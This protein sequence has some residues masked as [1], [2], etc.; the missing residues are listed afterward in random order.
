MPETGRGQF[1]PDRTSSHVDAQVIGF[2]SHF[3]ARWRAVAAGNTGT[4]GGMPVEGA[5]QSLG[6]DVL[7]L[8]AFADVEG[9]GNPAGVV[10]DARH[11][12]AE[13]MLAVA[14][15]IGYSETVFVTDG[16]I[17]EGRRSYTARYFS[18][19]A[20]VPFCGHATVALG[21]AL[22]Q[23]VGA[24]ELT[25]HTKAGPVV[26]AAAPNIGGR[27]EATLTSPAPSQEELAGQPLDELL[28]CFGWDRSVL[29][30]SMEPAVIAAGARHALLPLARRSSLAQVTPYDFGLL[31]E[32]CV[33]HQWVTVHVVWSES[34]LVH[35]VRSPFPY[36]GI[37]EDPATGAAAAAFG[38][39]LREVGILRAPAT[40]TLH[41]GVEMGRPSR[42]T[43]RIPR[44]GSP[45]VSG[46]VREISNRAD[47]ADET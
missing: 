36:G 14:S 9:G 2:F 10:L 6:I 4:M 7:G 27:W 42:L 8:A 38:A 11:L 45:Q 15:R 41:Q 18:P 37:V 19:A 25:L 17:E 44:N 22:G 32:L 33:R 21:V 46:A 13:E 28:G 35:Y 29:R 5:S 31:R 20:E 23:R 12:G 3:R 40:V 26:V 39:Y 1:D 47:V 30:V 16:P 43:V 24:G 34:A